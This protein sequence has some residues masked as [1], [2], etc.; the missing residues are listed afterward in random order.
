MLNHKEERLCL[1]KGIRE[2]LYVVCQLSMV[3]QK[4][5]VCTIN[6]DLSSLAQLHVVVAAKRSE[7]PVLGY[8]DLLATGELV[9]GAAESLD[10][11]GAVYLVSIDS[12]LVAYTY[13]Y[14]ESSRTG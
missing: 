4:L 14:R 1:G 11:S 10:G 3:R 9:L 8:N 5:N 13:S 6:L 12:I 7:S 2:S